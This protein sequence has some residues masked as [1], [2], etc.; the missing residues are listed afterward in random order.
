VPALAQSLVPDPPGGDLFPKKNE[1]GCMNPELCNAFNQLYFSSP[2]K[3]YVMD[4][5]NVFRTTDAGVTWVPVLGTASSHE[6]RGGEIFFVNDSTFFVF[7][8]PPL[9]TTDAG[10]TFATLSDVAPSHRAKGATSRPSLLFFQDAQHGWGKGDGAVVITTDGG[11]TW[12]TFD[13]T[14]GLDPP[15][16]MWMFDERQGL[17]IAH[18]RLLR[19]EDGGQRWKVLPNTPELDQ[20]RCGK[21]GFCVGEKFPDPVVHISADQGRTWQATQTGL[22]PERDTVR[23][24]HIIA[25]G[26][27]ALV[28]THAEPASVLR[29]FDI[30]TPMPTV[31]TTPAP[32]HAFLLRW[33]GSAWQRTDY[34]DIGTLR[35]VFYLTA[36]D[37]W[38]SADLNGLLRSSDGG[39]TWTFVPDYYRQIA[40]LTPSEPPFVSPTPPPPTP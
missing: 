8:H 27:A 2:T 25:A 1:P 12:L 34:P 29:N 26:G 40:A 3:G 5:R 35:T 7:S 23:D 22:D 11:Q 31:S 4:D 38:A 28:G 9:R 24:I 18:P 32:P 10:R 13:M 39:Q 15:T 20:V 14:T 33:D 19:T 37:V 6:R 36:S 21:S 16:H 17:G 30:R